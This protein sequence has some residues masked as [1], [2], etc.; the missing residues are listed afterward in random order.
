VKCDATAVYV[1]ED[2]RL[3]CEKCGMVLKLE[4]TEVCKGG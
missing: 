3:V 2:G 4:I 1:L